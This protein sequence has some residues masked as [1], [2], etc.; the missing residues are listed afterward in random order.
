[1]LDFERHLQAPAKFS[2]ES[3]VAVA[4]LAAEMKIAVG[5][6][7]VVSQPEKDVEQRHRVG[8][9]AHGCNNR[10]PRSRKTMRYDEIFNLFDEMRFFHN[11]KRCYNN[12]F[13]S[14][15]FGSAF[16]NFSGISSEV[17]YVATPK[18]LS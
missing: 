11:A 2:H 5:G 1:M 7:D 6:Y 15:T 18:G 12:F 9:A 14:S 3:L 13:K 10:G 8:T 4:F 17:L 16:F